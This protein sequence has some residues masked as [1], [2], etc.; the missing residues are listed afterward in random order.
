MKLNVYFGFIF[1]NECNDIFINECNDN[2][3]SDG[4]YRESDFIS[5]LFIRSVA[6]YL[7]SELPICHEDP[8]TGLKHSIRD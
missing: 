2:A 5:R 1:I 8:K 3:N 4:V 6:I 7:N